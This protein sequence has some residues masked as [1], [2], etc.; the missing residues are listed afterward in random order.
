M[1]LQV[2]KRR[3]QG[4]AARLFVIYDPQGTPT[5]C[6]PTSTAPS[7]SSPSS[8]PPCTEPGA[9]EPESP[10]ASSSE[11]PLGSGTTIAQTPP[12]QAAGA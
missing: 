10:P 4:R 3:G 7:S 11:A 1:V 2:G 5:T 9:S 6:P 8:E 12:N